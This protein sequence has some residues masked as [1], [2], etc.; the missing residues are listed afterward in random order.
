MSDTL[1][2]GAGVIGLM[3]ARALAIKGQ[4]VTLL[5]RQSFGRASSWAGGGIVSPLYPWRYQDAVTQLASWSQGQ[6]P[7]LSR[8]LREQTGVDP[9]FDQQ[10][11]LLLDINDESEALSWS[12]RYE[13]ELTRVDSQRLCELEPQL[14]GSNRNGLWMPEVG[15]IRNPRLL[16]ALI[17]WVRQSSRVTSLENSGE[18]RLRVHKGKI[19]GVG[20]ANY[21]KLSAGKVVVAAGAWSGPILNSVGVDLPVVPVRGQM[22][23]YKAQPGLIK[24]IT[25][26]GNRYVIPRRD[27]RILVGSSLE[28]EGYNAYPTIEQRYSLE[29]TAQEII[30]ALADYPVEKHWAG[31][32]PGSS[33]GVPFIGEVTN[34]KGLYVSAGHFRNGLVLAPASTHLLACQITG[35]RCDLDPMPYCVP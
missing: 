23:L 30:P 3:L 11:L 25:L 26:V 21:G 13:R 4:R 17:R 29:R 15:S 34:T 24:R 19:E 9:E 35:E 6:Y 28:Y 18:I 12:A 27:G 8:E 2:I 7:K 22:L 31:L 20:S 5:D 1:I 14:Q 32:R 16:Q 33:Q 10:G